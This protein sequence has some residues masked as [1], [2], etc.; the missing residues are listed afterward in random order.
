MT[1]AIAEGVLDENLESMTLEPKQRV[2]RI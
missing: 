1:K 2:T